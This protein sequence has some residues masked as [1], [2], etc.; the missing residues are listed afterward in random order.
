M[1]RKSYAL[2]ASGYKNSFRELFQDNR[3]PHQGFPLSIIDLDVA[4]DQKTRQNLCDPLWRQVLELQNALVLDD[5]LCGLPRLGPTGTFV[6]NIDSRHRLSSRRRV[7]VCF[8][9]SVGD[10]RADGTH[11]SRNEEA[12]PT[13]FF[14]I[15]NP[16]G[17]GG[18]DSGRTSV[19]EGRFSDLR[20][21]GIARRVVRRLQVSGKFSDNSRRPGS[22]TE[23]NNNNPST[24]SHLDI[25]EDISIND[26]LADDLPEGSELGIREDEDVEDE[27]E[28]DD[29]NIDEQELE[30]LLANEDED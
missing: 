24:L 30:T 20:L 27:E 12:E 19:T 1:A 22:C 3:D 23:E 25:D 29:I 7:G 15:K 13:L 9:P 4:E 6:E 28:E 2:G 5:P 10:F 11:S 17:D 14:F 16:V 26:D 21:R 18:E 8:E